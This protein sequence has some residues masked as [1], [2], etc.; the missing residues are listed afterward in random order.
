MNPKQGKA[1]VNLIITEVNLSHTEAKYAQVS[2][3]TWV[4]PLGRDDPLEKG[5]V[6][7]GQTRLSDFHFFTQ[8]REYPQ[9]IQTTMLC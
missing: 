8:E 5:M 7:K 3:E 4:Q 1:E 2:K 9:Q 6:A